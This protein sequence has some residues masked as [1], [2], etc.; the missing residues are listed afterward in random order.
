MFNPQTYHRPTTLPEAAQLLR[1]ADSIALSGGALLLGSLDLPYAHIVD[2]QALGE[3]RGID[4]A[5]TG[6][7]IGGGVTL[8]EIAALP[9]LH[10][11]FRRA[12][13]RCI[14]LN[15]RNATSL[16]DSLTLPDSAMLAEWWAALAALDAQTHWH[17]A[18]EKRVSYSIAELL[19]H[20]EEGG[21]T[22]GI[23]T[24][25]DL[26]MAKGYRHALGAAHVS[27]TPADEPIVA[28]AVY[29]RLDA[30][31]TVDQLFGAVYGASNAPI[32]LVTLPVEP[33]QPIAD[34][35]I[36]G[37]LTALPDQLSPQD[38][39]RASADY[40]REMAV[41]CVRRALEE[42]MSQFV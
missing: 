35:R 23:L 31:S 21:G 9:G 39:W 11:V 8:S 33:H 3:L 13:T 41:V 14:P 19:A 12:L 24:Q 4:H 6:F 18:H 22:P 36:D 40:R 32:A 17:T 7:R 29:V 27:R 42:C 5:E 30:E 1:Q 38:D 16:H 10:P 26:M 34:V 15:I 25:V 28:A 37:L 2:L 20:W